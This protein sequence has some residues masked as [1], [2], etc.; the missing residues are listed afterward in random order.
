LKKKKVGNLFQDSLLSG[1]CESLTTNF[2]SPTAAAAAGISSQAR[3]PLKHDKNQQVFRNS[4]FSS[5]A[6]EK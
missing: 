6:M 4:I 2:N 1:V 3:I 5:D